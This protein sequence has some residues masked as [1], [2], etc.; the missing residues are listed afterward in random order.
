MK[1]L[2]LAS[3]AVITMLGL[4]SCSNDESNNDTGKTQNIVI[5]LPSNVKLASRAVEDQWE[6]NET[7]VVKNIMVFL[8]NGQVVL[9][10]EKFEDEEI[11]VHAK[12]VELA[13]ANTNY[14]LLVANYDENKE[15]QL[16]NL[17]NLTAI[18][19]FF[20]VASQNVLLKGQVKEK[21]LMGIGEPVI[22]GLNTDGHQLKTVTIKLESI[23]A[24]FEVGTVKAG[25]GIEEVELVGVFINNFYNNYNLEH[26]FYNS[27]DSHW[28][29]DPLSGTDSRAIDI[30]SV[31]NTFDPE[32]YYD[33]ADNENVTRAIGSM[34]YAYHVFEGNN[35]PHLILLVKGKYQLGFS[36]QG[37]DYPYFLKWVTFTKFIHNG[38]AITSIDKNVIY[39]M[40]VVKDTDSR[41]GGGD[42]TPTEEDTGITI[43]EEDLTDKPE[44]PMFDVSIEVEI[45]DWVSKYVTPSV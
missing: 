42:G 19:T 12:M 26:T 32:Q 39:K 44:T 24:R 36:P 3:L 14:V 29:T 17:P 8:M 22:S 30:V 11:N 20:D 16:K 25:T 7:G 35:I 2:G 45:I 43:N 13:P 27:E 28:T 6:D 31:T 9:R 1:Y 21:T 23:T 34:A 33:E 4:G 15:T 37:N 38:S 5:K 41:P 40:G 18:K 10:T